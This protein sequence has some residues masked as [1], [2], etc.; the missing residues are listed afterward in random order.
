[1]IAARGPGT[2]D[3]L[4][5]D[6][7]TRIFADVDA[8]DLPFGARSLSRQLRGDPPRPE[9]LTNAIGLVVDHL[10]DL[11]RDVPDIAAAT[12]VRLRGREMSAIAAVELGTAAVPEVVVLE[13]AA[14]EDVFRTL[15][16]ERATDR[17][18]NPGLPPEMVHEVV[19]ACCL[20]VAVMR[21]LQLDAVEITTPPTAAPTAEVRA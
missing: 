9:E 17:R 12:V 15:A 3:L 4:V 20:L 2:I 14:A 6:E 8:A 18:S 21:A 1:M 5:G 19:G 16:T 7:Q 11:A 10:D 13:R